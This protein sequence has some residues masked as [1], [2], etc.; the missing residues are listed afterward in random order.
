MWSRLTKI[1]GKA[2]FGNVG[3]E[4]E[5]SMQRHMVLKHSPN[6]FLVPLIEARMQSMEI[7]LRRI[8]LVTS[9]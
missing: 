9:D 5:R 3:K 8:V 6:T 1:G 7:A 2:M 4:I